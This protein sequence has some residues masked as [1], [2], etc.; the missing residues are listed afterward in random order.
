[1]V[2]PLAIGFTRMRPVQGGTKHPPHMFQIVLKLAAW[3][4]IL[5][6]GREMDCKRTDEEEEM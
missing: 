5:G 1:M 6:E 3:G 2:K 4:F